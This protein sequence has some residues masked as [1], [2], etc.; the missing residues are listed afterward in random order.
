M[1]MSGQLHALPTLSLWNSPVVTTGMAVRWAPRGDLD[2][3]K[4]PLCFVGR[5]CLIM[6]T[7]Q[8]SASSEME[9]IIIISIFTE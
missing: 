1:E 4:N 5:Q 8:T 9:D 2:E 7:A 6:E 3:K